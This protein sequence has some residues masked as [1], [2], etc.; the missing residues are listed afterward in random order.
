MIAIFIAV[1]SA[2]AAAQ[3]LCSKQDGQSMKIYIRNAT[4]KTFTVNYVDG[5]CK[6]SPSDEK[7]EPG[8]AF[9]GDVT[10][11]EVF[12]VREAG[13]NNLI[14]EV[15]ADS[16]NTTTTIGIVKNSDPRQS[17]IQTL[18]QVRRGRNLPP[19]EFNDSLNQG[20]QWF[21]DLMAK[22]DKGGHDAVLVGGNSYVDMQ[23]PWMRSK[24]FGYNG[25]GGT[26]ATA[27]GD[28]T[29]IST[30]GGDVMMGWSSS[31][32]HF[33]PFLS[34]DNQIF[35]QVGFGYAKSLKKPNYY[36]T[37][38]VFGNPAETNSGGR[39]Q[40]PQANSEAADKEPVKSDVPDRLKFTE[41]K[42]F[43]MQNGAEKYGT[44]FSKNALDEL[45]AEF[46]FEN[47]SGEPFNVEAR[48]YLNGKVISS[49]SMK[50]LKGT[51]AMS[52]LV[53]GESGKPGKVAAGNYRFEIL[54]NGEVVLSA[55][56]AVK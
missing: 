47:P 23:E 37:C 8:R 11:G 18:N 56:A 34:M 41:A 52:V 27:E 5:K 25:D 36:Y 22:Y 38:A 40:N 43:Q 17:F 13:T 46:S 6:E 55:E 15:V 24:K 21:A 31:D 28:V 19:I 53:A 4:D 7:I 20:C 32:T 2:S 35:K 45:N 26:E 44:S 54:L 30:L 16:E 42:F 10:G 48:S 9:S 49:E 51:G 3:N 50:D 14:K 39:N 29:D 12:R 33:R 1:A